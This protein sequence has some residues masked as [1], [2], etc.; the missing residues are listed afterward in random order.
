MGVN[1]AV[2][3]LWREFSM[4][5]VEASAWPFLWVCMPIVVVGTPLGAICGSYLRWLTLAW[6]VYFIEAAQLIG[7]LAVVRPWLSEADGG[8][9]ATT[10]HPYLTSAALFC[11]GAVFFKAVTRLGVRLM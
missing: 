9:T 5:G 2:G 10:L 11:G 4:G 8:N 7:A 6:L 1:P 3:F